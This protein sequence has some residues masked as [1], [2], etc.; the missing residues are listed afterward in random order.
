MV[1]LTLSASAELALS[2][3]LLVLPLNALQL[4]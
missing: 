2:N 3:F 1:V 4:A